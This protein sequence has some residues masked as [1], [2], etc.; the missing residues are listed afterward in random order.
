MRWSA[1]RNI[2]IDAQPD[3][4]GLRIWTSFPGTH[5]RDPTDHKSVIYSSQ[6]PW[7]SP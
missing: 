7:L 6:I 3:G 4:D 2:G 5:R 1:M